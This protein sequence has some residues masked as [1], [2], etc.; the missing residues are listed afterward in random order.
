MYLWKKNQNN[1]GWKWILNTIRKI[2]CLFISNIF[3]KIISKIFLILSNIERNEVLFYH[4][5]IK[6]GQ[7]FKLSYVRNHNLKSN[8]DFSFFIDM[9]NMTFF[10]QILP[11]S[12]HLRFI[13][14]LQF[15]YL[16]LSHFTSLFLNVE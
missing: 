14:L 6:C 13:Y 16:L 7:N 11:I 9:Q 5:R 3:T 10:T 8:M 12:F 2:Y 1:S 15:I 4:I